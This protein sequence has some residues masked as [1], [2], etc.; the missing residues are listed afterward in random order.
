MAEWIIRFIYE[1]VTDYWTLQTIAR[2]CRTKK[3]RRET[4]PGAKDPIDL[5]RTK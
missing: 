1:L 5:M 3:P 2:L 4:A